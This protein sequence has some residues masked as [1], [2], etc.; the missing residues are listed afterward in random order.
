MRIRNVLLIAAVGTGILRAQSAVETV[1]VISKSVERTALL[2]GEL[3]PYLRTDL[4][5]KVTGF[6]EKVSVDRGSTVAE[7]A[8]LVTL[9][10]PELAAQLAEAE[11]RV[12]AVESQRAEAAAKLTAA[13]STYERLKAAS[14]TP[15]VVAENDLVLAGKA[16]DAARSAASAFSDQIKAASSAAAA[17]RDLQGYLTVTA[18]YDGIITER[19]VHPGALVGP[20]GERSAPLLK[21]EQIS[22]L[23]LTVAVPEADVGA[24]VKGARVIFTVPAYPGQIFEG[25]IARVSHSLD[26]K[27]RTM[28][29]ELDVENPGLKLSP[30]MY[31]EVRWPIRR[32]NPSLLVPATSI[33]TTTERSFVIRIKAG[34]AEWVSVTRGAPAGDLVEVYGSL[35]AGDVVVRRGT[36]ELREGTRVQATSAPR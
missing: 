12:A 13:E 25:V 29:V 2:P 4:Y 10:A 5:A 30:G 27:T 21:I 36:D 17:I 1:T 24:L 14:A 6:V 32:T 22:R 33:V 7:G 19:D 28:P 15:G 9:S 31:P 35:K 3:F 18:P 8:R 20:A 23:R 26:M 34:V 16:V 11:S